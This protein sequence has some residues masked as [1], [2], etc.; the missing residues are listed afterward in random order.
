MVNSLVVSDHSLFNV[1]SV[2]CR[3]AFLCDVIMSEMFKRVLFELAKLG[4]EVRQLW[5]QVDNPCAS[6]P[7]DS[8]RDMIPEHRDGPVK[9]VEGYT[10]LQH[11]CCEETMQHSLVYFEV[12]YI[13]IFFHILDPVAD[14][15]G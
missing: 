12:L 1:I 13:F 4:S 11:R 15:I 10:S 3:C 2:T 7:Y 5:R 9:T 6:L 14:C 8:S